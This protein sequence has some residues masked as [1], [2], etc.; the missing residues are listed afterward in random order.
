[1]HLVFWQP[2]P[3]FH[4]EGFLNAL[5]ASDWVCSVQLKYESPIPEELKQSGWPEPKWIKVETR[6][7]QPGEAPEDSPDYVH[8]FT[9]FNTHPKVWAAF[10]RLPTQRQ[11]RV[12]A[13]TEAPAL[14]GWKRPLRILKYR[15]H[16]RALARRLDGVLAI[17]GKGTAFY[18]SILDPVCPVH[19]FA[20]YDQPLAAFPEIDDRPPNTQVAFLYVGR[21][22]RLKGLDRLF[23]ALAQLPKNTPAWTLTLVGEGTE[24]GKLQALAGQLGIADRLLWKGAVPANQVAS[25]YQA[26]DYLIQPSRGDG[27]GMTLP[28]ALRHGCDIIATE[29]CGAA[30]LV[31]A[32]M[33]LS[34]KESTW[35]HT[36]AKVLQ[37]GSL[38]PAQRMHNQTRARA[39]S[40]DEGLKR[41][42]SILMSSSMV[43]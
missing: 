37:Q 10:D 7:I 16:A 35:P 14:Y 40:S 8:F 31:D 29:A 12:Y 36:L 26:A 32:A 39:V 13:L 15:F 34:C 42:R 1:M 17:G 11:C 5:A 3:S 22:I 24:T 2:I 43:K 33:R 28:E 27:W 6:E 25:F 9:G 23:H 38:T 4:Q 18:R 20:Y 19:D 21:L 30:M 41:M